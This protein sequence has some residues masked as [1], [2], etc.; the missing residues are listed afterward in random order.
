MSLRITPS[1]AE[2]VVLFNASE[3]S[4]LH[5]LPGELQRFLPDSQELKTLSQHLVLTLLQRGL[6]CLYDGSSDSEPLRQTQAEV[7]I[8][9]DSDWE[10]PRAGGRISHLVL[11][12]AG[13]KA[14]RKYP[15]LS[16]KRQHDLIDI[17]FYGTY[18]PGAPERRALRWKSQPVIIPFC[19]L[20]GSLLGRLTVKCVGVFRN[21]KPK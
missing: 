6:I 18:V 5:E 13:L 2:Y 17:L 1:D 10:T 21:R 11:T 3:E 9:S 15:G 19:R 8:A 7:V 20:A 16:K 12:D 4:Y 14:L